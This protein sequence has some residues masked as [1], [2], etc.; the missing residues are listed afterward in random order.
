MNNRPES[1][2]DTLAN[3]YFRKSIELSPETATYLGSD[4]ADKGKLDDYS[5]EGRAKERDLEAS[6]LAALSR[7]EPVDEV[8]RITKAAMQ[9]RLGLSIELHDSG[10]S[11]APLRVIASPL[12]SI[13][14]IFDLMPRETPQDWETIGRRLSAVPEAVAQYRESLIWRRDNGPAI[15]ARQVQRCAEQADH[16]AGES[17]AFSILIAD[18]PELAEQAQTARA[19]YGELASFLR[20]EILPTA[21]EKD[22]VGSERYQL[23][24]RYFLGSTIDMEETYEW[25]KEQLANIISEQEKIAEKLYGP[26]TSVREA[27]TRLDE[28]PSRQIQGVKAFQAWMQETADTAMSAMEAHF[29]IPEPMRRI[30]CCIADSGTGAVYYTG[31]TDDFSR[32]GR[33][34]WAVPSGVEKFSTWQEKTTIHHEGVPGHHL[35]IGLATYLS[36]TLNDWRRQGCWVSGHG[37]GW[38]LY[39]EQLM[40]EL[41]LMDEPGDRMGV[42]DAMRLRAARVVVDLG[43]HLGKPAGKWGEGA[44]NHDSAWEFLRTNLAGDDSFLRFELNRYLGWPG[45]APAYKIG[46][47]IWTDLREEARARATAQG[48][49]FNLTDWHMKALSVGSVGLDVL[50]E[51][52]A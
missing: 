16:T 13:S 23:N 3:E 11:I 28:E 30:E 34:W 46:Q 24:S 41:G 43:V 47:R 45:Q 21:T 7:L 49:E 20:T 39:S 22:G 42:L 52:L 17:S 10:E 1:A 50:R 32:P 4:A 8:D 35:Q 19:A 5:I 51:A 29:D 25:G 44:W 2:I 38:A 18:H 40:V 6:T 31:P 27:M 12:Q 9:E 15:Q 14:E 26:G 37:E 36:S 33:M 48:K